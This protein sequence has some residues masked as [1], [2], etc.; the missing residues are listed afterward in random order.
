MARAAVETVDEGHGGGGMGF[1]FGQ[2]RGGQLPVERTSFVGRAEEIALVQEAFTQAPLVTLVGPG[3]VGKSRTALRAAD[4]LGERFPDGVWL[5]ELSGLRDPELVPATLAAVLEL[6]EQ[7]GMEPLDAVVAHLRG[8]RLLIVLDTCEHLVDACAMLCDVLLREAADA[9]VLATSR[10]P[11]DVPGEQCLTIAPLAAE[12]AVEL[13]VQRAIAVAPGFAADEDNR[14]QLSALVGRLDGIPLALELAA[15]RLR[16]VP[17]AHLVARLDQRFGVLTGGRRTA[18]A[19]HQTLRTAIDWSY[20][21][22]VPQEREL[23]VRL[24]VFAGSFELATAEEV[25]AGGALPREEVLETLVGLVDKSV[26]QHLSGE[27]GRYRLLDTLRAYGAEQLAGTESAASVREAHFAYYRRL[28]QRLWD[29]LLTDA[30]AGLYRTVRAEVADVRAALGYAYAT[31][32]LARQGLW[33]AAQLVTFW[34]A[35]GT[36]SEGRYWIDKGLAQVPED[37]GER[38]WGLLLGGVLAVWGGDLAVAPGRFEEARAVAERCGEERVV[39]FADPYLGAMRAFGGEVEEGLADLERGR[40]RIMAAGDPLGISVMHSEGALVRAVFGDTEG[41]LD[42]CG[43]G[44][45]HLKDSGDRQ[46]YATTLMVQGIILWLAGRYED[47]APSLRRA[48]DA[49]SEVG[50]VLVAALSCLGLAWYAARQQRYPRAAWLLGYA[51]SARRLAGDP[52]AML[53]SLLEQQESAQRTVREA[54]GGTA[55]A[56][57]HGVGARMTGTEILAA[58]RADADLPPSARCVPGSR[59]GRAADPLTPREREVAELVARGLSNREVA[60]RLVIS[61]RTAD[62]HVERILTKLG[63]RSRAEIPGTLDG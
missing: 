11:L 25:C 32:G 2:R 26:V 55:F 57:W 21:L 18:L 34:R 28:G 40:Q 23:W 54:L 8:R 48:L 53:P 24:S 16:A 43:T 1:G 6:P 42:L 46:L 13:F 5:A 38:A 52:V 14:A 36:L 49:A 58:V 31:A 62:T 50:D 44:L 3:G 19:R 63:L 30:Q 9:C 10:Q 37:C 20:E 61:K 27:A 29:E 12:D 56:R 7:P 17:L 22:C 15:V 41:A 51:E 35:A 59:Q 33:L 4:G 45:A 39:L 60:E 47:G